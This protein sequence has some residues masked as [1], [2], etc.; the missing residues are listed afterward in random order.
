VLVLA[1]H[2]CSQNGKRIKICRFGFQYLINHSLAC[3]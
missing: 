3:S 2:I 1:H